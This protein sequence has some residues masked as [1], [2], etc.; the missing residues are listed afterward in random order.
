MLA[1]LGQTPHIVAMRK[2]KIK[3]KISKIEMASMCCLHSV[4]TD[5]V[6]FGGTLDK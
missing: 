1:V 5:F 2:N 6:L 4:K 3:I